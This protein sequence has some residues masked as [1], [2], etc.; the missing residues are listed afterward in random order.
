MYACSS[1]QGLLRDLSSH[2]SQGLSPTPGYDDQC[3]VINFKSA[4]PQRVA[5]TRL[6]HAGKVDVTLPSE[7]LAQGTP[8]TPLPAHPAAYPLS[9]PE[10]HQRNNGNQSQAQKQSSRARPSQC[11]AG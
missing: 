9:Q 6:A 11:S 1:E 5:T 2:C 10:W 8:A 4:D 3:C 7:A